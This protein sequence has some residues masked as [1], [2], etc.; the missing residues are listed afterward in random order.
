LDLFGFAMQ[1]DEWGKRDS[2]IMPLVEKDDFIYL[3]IHV[4]TFPRRY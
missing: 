4:V 3:F 2:G 1:G